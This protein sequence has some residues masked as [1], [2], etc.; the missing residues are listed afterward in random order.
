MLSQPLSNAI[1]RICQFEFRRVT[2]LKHSAASRALTPPSLLLPHDDG[3]DQAALD[4]RTK[5][6]RWRSGGKGSKLS[7]QADAG[8]ELASCEGDTHGMERRRHLHRGLQLRG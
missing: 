3:H 5:K 2:Q 1:A 4:V 7:M 8:A 6:T